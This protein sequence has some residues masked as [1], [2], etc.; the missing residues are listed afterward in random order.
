M[1]YEPMLAKA[2]SISLKALATYPANEAWF[3]EQKLDGKRLLLQIEDGQVVVYNRKGERIDPTPHKKAIEQFAGFA[4]S[5]CFDGEWIDSTLWVFDMPVALAIVSETTPYEE[6]RRALEAVYQQAWG[7]DNPQIKLLDVARTEQEKIDLIA[8]CA[9][10]HAE[11][12]MLKARA[13]PYLPGE[14]SHGML[15]AKYTETADCIILEPRRQG[16]LSSSLTLYHN[17]ELIIGTPDDP[18]I[19]SC[20]MT[21]EQLEQAKPGDVAE[22]KYL[23]TTE[24][25]RL[26]Q[27]S[28]LR[29]RDDKNPEEC[30]TA[31]LKLTDKTVRK[32]SN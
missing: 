30:T 31:Q 11:G 29:F 18:G 23:Y 12:V 20:K 24:G 28:F 9:T 14:R 16:K 27:P 19:G 32:V 8:W 6:R 1:K 7:D 15:K 22:I 10:N 13:G 17:G 4:G 25:L 21:E 26:Y 2:R 5:W 3:A